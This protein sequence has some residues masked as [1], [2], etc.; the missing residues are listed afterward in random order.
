VTIIKRMRIPVAAE[1]EWVS[2]IPGADR[3]RVVVVRES[4]E[5]LQ[6]GIDAEAPLEPQIARE[7]ETRSRSS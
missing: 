5:E 3:K 7:L 2:V 6:I 1:K 4:G